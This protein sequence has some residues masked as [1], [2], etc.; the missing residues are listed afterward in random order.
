VLIVSLIEA[1]LQ[2]KIVSAFFLGDHTR[3]ILDVGNEQTITAETVDRREFKPGDVVPIA[4]DAE[5]LLF[6]E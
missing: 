1:Q 6:L 2:A 4:V 5:A 3:L